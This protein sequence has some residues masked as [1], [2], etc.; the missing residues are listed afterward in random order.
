MYVRT[1]SL[2]AREIYIRDKREKTLLTV[3]YLI[4]F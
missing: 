1:H 2:W 4:H 3:A